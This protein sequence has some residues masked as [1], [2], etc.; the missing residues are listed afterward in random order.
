MQSGVMSVMFRLL[1]GP[2]IIGT[3][4]FLFIYF[5]S[6][7]IISG[8][9]IVSIVAEFVLNLS[10]LYFEN[11]PPIIAGYIASLNL[12]IVAITV[13]L[14]MTVVIQLLVIIWGIFSFMARW[15]ISL[16]HKDRL[17]DE[18]QDLP[19]IDMDSSFKTSSIGKG[20]FGRGLDSID[21]DL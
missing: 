14:V 20:V 16:L 3:L 17:E 9:R 21:R 4:T 13:G 10:T 6:P 7:V 18:S 5:V 8:P 15:V 1:I 12:T 2:V 11:T 19:A